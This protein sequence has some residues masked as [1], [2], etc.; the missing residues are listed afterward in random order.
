MK[1]HNQELQRLCNILLNQPIEQIPLIELRNIISLCKKQDPIEKKDS[2]QRISAIAQLSLQE[3]QRRL[4]VNPYS[5]HN[6]QPE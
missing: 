2:E 3:I 5:S 6:A 4:C 1:I